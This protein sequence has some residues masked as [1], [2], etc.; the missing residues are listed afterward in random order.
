MT[1]ANLPT[2][3]LINIEGMR[4]AGCVAAVEK[5]LLATPG[6]VSASVNL[7]TA[8]AVVEHQPELTLID[9]THR[10]TAKGFPSRLRDLQEITIPQQT[11]DAESLTQLLIALGLLALSIAGHFGQSTMLPHQTEDKVLPC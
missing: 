9:L 8:M 5:H 10:L 1:T 3:A 4:C 2:K 7:L 6:V 11:N